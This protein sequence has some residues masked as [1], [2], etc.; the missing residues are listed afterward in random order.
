[1][2]C[3]KA[4]QLPVLIAP[5]ANDARFEPNRSFLAAGTPRHERE[6]FR[7][8]FLAAKGR[9][10][11]DPASAIAAY[12]SL[13]ARQP[14]FAEA[15]YRLARLLE[16]QEAWQEAYT[17]YVQAR[18]HDGYPQ[19][20]LT[21][22]QGVYSEIAERHRCIL[23]DGQKYFHAI[24]R[25]GLL[26]DF[27]FQDGMHPSLRG[28]IALAQRVLEALREHRALGWP[29]AKP[30]PVI[31]PAT[32]IRKFGLGRAEW[33][34]ICLWGILFHDI[35]HGMRYDPSERLAAKRL[36]ATAA[37]R[38]ASGEAPEALGLPNV[39]IPEAVPLLDETRQMKAERHRDTRRP[40]RH[41]SR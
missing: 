24:G 13:L 10:Q 21:E 32:C 19:R 36:Y 20:A 16:R 1:M 41:R 8:D 34:E 17:H 29:D 37:D 7:R 3:R 31:D 39:G 33:R 25:H 35:T 6:A 26:D 5:P 18:D 30:A 22:F 38:L 15:H 27:L 28:Q 9:E 11:H 14:G 23:I 2:L 4:G 12:R 40:G